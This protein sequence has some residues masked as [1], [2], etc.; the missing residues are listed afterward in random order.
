MMIRL[1]KS[2]L[3][4]HLFVLS[5]LVSG[6]EFRGCE[7]KPQRVQS[8]ESSAQSMR[9]HRILHHEAIDL[10]AEVDRIAKNHPRSTIVLSPGVYRPLR[11]GIALLHLN[12]LHDGL[13]IKGEHRD[14]VILS[15]QAL[16]EVADRIRNERLGSLQSRIPSENAI[17][18]H[19]VYFGHGVT[20]DT[21]LSNLTL[22]GARGFLTRKDEFVAEPYREFPRK[23]VKYADG[24][25]VKIWGQSAPSLTELIIEDN[26][27]LYC[28]G[29]VSVEQFGM[30]S[31]PVRIRNVI[32]RDNRVPLTGAAL[33]LLPGSSA[34][35]EDSTF[36]RNLAN[37]EWV[38]LKVVDELRLQFLAQASES[39]RKMVGVQSGPTSSQTGPYAKSSAV[40]VFRG[41]WIEL[42]R[43]QFI[44]NS[45]GIDF[46]NYVAWYTRSDHVLRPRRPSVLEGLRFQGQGLHDLKGIE[47]FAGG[48]VIVRDAER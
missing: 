40:T 2:L 23:F 3:L 15:A 6:C 14:T 27:A 12:R 38:S 41:S 4:T 30:S 39:V 36:D 24:G 34:R 21:E 1:P 17:V 11:E 31:E 18:S 16:P 45:G 33:D 10:Q 20:N 5:F 32:F 44:G 42:K 25:A 13:K 7:P 28:G 22:K 37:F 26:W 43:S 46:L 48:R 47:G 9:V 19:I 29:G 8:V 35:V